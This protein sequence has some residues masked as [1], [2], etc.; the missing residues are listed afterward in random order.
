MGT[1]TFLSAYVKKC[2]KEQFAHLRLAVV[3]AEKLKEPLANAFKEKFG[4]SAI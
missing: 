2:T 4:C 3:G 1:P